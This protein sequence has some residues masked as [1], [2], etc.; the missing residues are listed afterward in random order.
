MACRILEPQK[1]RL[2]KYFKKDEFW[3]YWEV[4]TK[5]KN[6]DTLEPDELKKLNLFLK[7]VEEHLGLSKKQKVQLYGNKPYILIES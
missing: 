2:R 6:Q 1:E 7:K 3:P 4:L 5:A